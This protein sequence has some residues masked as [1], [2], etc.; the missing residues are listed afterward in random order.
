MIAND[1]AGAAKDI[2]TLNT[3]LA[4]I[5]HDLALDAGRFKD[6]VGELKQAIEED[7]KKTRERIAQVQTKLADEEADDQWAK[8]KTRRTAKRVH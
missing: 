2:H 8:A 3:Q 7:G 6:G 4:S 5:R 1:A